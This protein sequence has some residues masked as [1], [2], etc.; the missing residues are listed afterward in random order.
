MTI[1]DPATGWF[2]IVEVPCCDLN[3]VA[4]GNNEYIDKSSARVSQRH[5]YAGTPIH[6][7]SCFTM[8]LSLS[9]TSFLC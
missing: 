5:V 7:R 6:V 3:E 4:R 8:V 1:I 9:E 2:E